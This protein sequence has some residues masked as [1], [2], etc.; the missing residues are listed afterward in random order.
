MRIGADARKNSASV[1]PGSAPQRSARPL[2]SYQSSP[3]PSRSASWSEEAQPDLP[4]P[5]AAPL[6]AGPLYLP[7]TPPPSDSPPS[8][9]KLFRTSSRHS[10]SSSPRRHRRGRR[11]P[12]RSYPRRHAFEANWAVRLMS[13]LVPPIDR[14]LALADHAHAGS[15]CRLGPPR[16]KRTVAPSP[17]T[18]SG[19]TAPPPLPGPRPSDG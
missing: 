11:S 3:P 10:E 15:R 18:A 5:T 13:L 19:P 4:R 12:C 1:C 17:P 2:N 16:T 7:T 9:P 14:E 6:P 8:G